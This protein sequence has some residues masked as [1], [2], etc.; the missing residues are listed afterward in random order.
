MIKYNV[1]E[2]YKCIFMY[3]KNVNY[4]KIKM[5]KKIIFIIKNKYIYIY[6]IVKKHLYK[7]FQNYKTFYFVNIFNVC[8]L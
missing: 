7:I 6:T 5:I 3:K 4:K 1:L 2:L 8:K